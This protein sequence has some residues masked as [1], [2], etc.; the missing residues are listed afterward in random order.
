MDA[1][2]DGGFGSCKRQAE[3]NMGTTTLTE[4][5]SRVKVGRYTNPEKI[6]WQ[7]WLEDEAE[8]WIVFVAL[9]GSVKAYLRRE[10][11][12]AVIDKYMPPKNG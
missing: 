12:G 9:D 4:K 1:P 3:S 6:G 10:K 7:G 11:D 8:T 2:G 5:S